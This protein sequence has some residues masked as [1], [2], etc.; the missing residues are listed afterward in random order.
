VPRRTS[1]PRTVA[2]T[3]LAAASSGCFAVIPGAQVEGG[4]MPRSN[5]PEAAVRVGVHPPLGLQRRVDVGAG[6][7]Q[8]GWDT[9][10]GYGAYGGAAVFPLVDEG[11]HDTFRRLGVGAQIR[12]ANHDEKIGW[13]MAMQ[14]VGEVGAWGNTSNSSGALYGIAGIGVYVEV[15]RSQIGPVE[16]WTGGGG[17]EVRLP[18]FAGLVATKGRR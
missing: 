1:C 13:G 3:L 15:A 2:V 10:T 12:S 9:K 11:K 17:L 4:Y 7:W 18:F 16:Q 8:D 5:G 6:Y 14:A